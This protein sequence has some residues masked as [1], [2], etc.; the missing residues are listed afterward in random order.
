[1]AKVTVKLFGVLRIDTHISCEELDAEKVLDIF[2]ALN[3]KADEI[4]SKALKKDNETKKPSPISFRNAVVFINGER[5]AQ[6]GKRLCGN[7]EVW[8]LSPSSGG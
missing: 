8:I 7:D 2:V 5:C 6:K 1:M 3:K 4:Y